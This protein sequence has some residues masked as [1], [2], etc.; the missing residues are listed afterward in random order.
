MPPE[1]ISALTHQ[2]VAALETG[3]KSPDALRDALPESSVRRLGAAGKKLG[4]TTTLPTALRHLEWAGKLRRIHRNGRVDTN[5]YEWALSEQ[6]LVAGAPGAPETQAVEL[7]RRYFDWAGPATLTE[8]VAWTQVG[9]RVAKAAVAAL[10]LVAVELEG[11]EEVAYATPGA[12][13]TATTADDEV[14]LLPSQDN[15]FALRDGL[16]LLVDPR[17]HAR[18]VLSMG[19]RTQALGSARWF[20]QRPIV[21]QGMVIGFWEYDLDAGE[22]VY[23]GLDPVQGSLAD[24]LAVRAKDLGAFIRDQLDGSARSISIDSDKGIRRRV[25]ALRA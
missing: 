23:A 19:G 20:V 5:R 21:H 3:A 14:Y 6:D 2:V 10:E 25:A 17:H 4:H 9:K 15:Y 24:R 22:V 12:L 7:A 16:A 13:D 8:F 11:I 1:E 18:E